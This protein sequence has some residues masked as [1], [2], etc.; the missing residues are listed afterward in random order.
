M[1]V[2][3]EVTMTCNLQ[4]VDTAEVEMVA[5]VAEGEEEVAIVDQ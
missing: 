4:E 5:E 1:A 3:V 2:V